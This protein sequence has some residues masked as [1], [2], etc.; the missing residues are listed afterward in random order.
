MILKSFNYSQKNNKKLLVFLN[1]PEFQE[2]INNLTLLDFKI[3]EKIQKKDINDQFFKIISKIYYNK[4]SE[5]KK[6]INELLKQYLVSKDIYFYDPYE[7]ACDEN[8]KTCKIV[9][10][11]YEKIYFDYGHYTLEGSK[12]FG[13][14][15][16]LYL[17]FNQLLK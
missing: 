13:K 17:K 12:F 16:N 4:I 9:T 3:L 15:T 5:D 10:D 14:N 6:R 1:R 2:N 8:L 7:Y 11:N